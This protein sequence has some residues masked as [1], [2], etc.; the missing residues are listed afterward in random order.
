MQNVII[1]DAVQ[2]NLFDFIRQKMTH[3]CFWCVF[4]GDMLNQ[5]K[6]NSGD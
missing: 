6:K 4:F 2:I 5:I 1:R 3:F